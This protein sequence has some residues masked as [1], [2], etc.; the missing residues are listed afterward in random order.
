[1]L[2]MKKSTLIAS[3]L[4]AGLAASAPV[5][6]QTTD[7]P[8]KTVTIVVPFPPGGA[9]DAIARV[10]AQ[11]F[12]EQFKQ[13]FV[14]DNRPG[15]TGTIGAASVKRAA[16]D[17]YTLLFSSL[18]A[19]AITPH[20]IKGVAYDA[21]K[22]FD[23]ISV[24]V[25]APNVLVASPKQTAP[26]VA[27]VIAQLKAKPGTVSFASS[28]NGSSDHL[29]AELF[30]QQTGT[31]GLHVPYK[32]GGP[33]VNDLLG[34]QVDYSF[35]NVNTV[36][37]H[38]RA[39]TLRPIAVTGTKRSPVLPDVPTLAESGVQGAE[40]YSWQGFAA[41]KGLPPAVLTK[42]SEASMAAFKDP[43]IVKRL[44]EQ[45]LEIVNSTPAEMTTF[46]AKESARW[47]QLI[48]TRKITAD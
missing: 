47:K 36:I 29:S 42:I 1:M 34:S 20:L 24:P 41:P 2:A 44:T 14:I 5:V 21:S 15:A 4:L 3:C 10:M 18:G 33:A 39:K 13:S 26:T 43:A 30:W 16:P 38:I 45:G 7:W 23:Y 28:G 31:Q 27:D 32:G 9:T 19:Y 37:S 22:D 35:Q 12:Q 25:Q 40:I 46:Q 11:H 6:A 8:S 48:D 17:G